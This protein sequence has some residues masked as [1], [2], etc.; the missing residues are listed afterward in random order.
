MATDI[1][2]V[3]IEVVGGVLLLALLMHFLLQLAGADS[4]NPIAQS[5][6]RFT[7][8]ILRPLQVILPDLFNINLSALLAAIL[9]EGLVAMLIAPVFNM[10]APLGTIFIWS[11]LGVASVILEIYF[12]AMLIVIVS[13]WLLPGHRHPALLLVAQL[14]APIFNQCR[15]LIPSF[16]A[17]DFSPILGFVCIYILRIILN[18]LAMASS[19]PGIMM[20]G[21]S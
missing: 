19:L 8:P 9:V 3:L 13:S 16:G 5:I 18:H 4:T 21:F 17:L 15:R 11:C 6:L 1:F 12:F 7:H 2:L 20:I 10:T 14:T